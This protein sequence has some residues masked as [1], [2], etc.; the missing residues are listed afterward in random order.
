MHIDQVAFVRHHGPFQL[1]QE[2]D[3]L[4]PRSA[5]HDSN[6]FDSKLPDVHDT[7]PDLRHVGRFDVKCADAVF[8]MKFVLKYL[9]RF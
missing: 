2:E 1:M 5:G 8:I 6:A 3:K 4:I 7:L 9:P